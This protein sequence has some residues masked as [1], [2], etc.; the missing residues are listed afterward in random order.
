MLTSALISRVKGIE[1]DPDFTSTQILALLNEG[2]MSIA[3]GGE[4]DHGYPLLAPLPELSSSDTV[5]FAVDAT[6]VSLP[7]TYHRGVFF[8]VDAN[9]YKL[10]GYDS[11]IELLNRYPSLETGSTEVYAIKG[12]TLFYAPAQ[13]QDVTVHFFR[14]PVD[15]DTASDSEPDGIPEHLQERLLVSYAVMKMSEQI[16]IGMES[17]RPNT[18]FWLARHQAA[19]TDLERMIGPEDREPMTVTDTTNYIY[20]F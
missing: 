18:S 14:L 16:E 13:A 9:N 6:S 15:M 2:Q 5:T 12:S 19:L 11:H 1:P 3:G 7:A 17:S 4:R 10:S 8:V 20:N